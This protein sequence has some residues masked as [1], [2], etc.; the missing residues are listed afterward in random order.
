MTSSD[1]TELVE[2]A[3]SVARKVSLF[4]L[5]RAELMRVR[6][7]EQVENI[8]GQPIW[9]SMA[10][11]LLPSNG[12]RV[13]YVERAETDDQGAVR[14]AAVRNWRQDGRALLVPIRA[15][16]SHPGQDEVGSDKE[17]NML[18]RISVRN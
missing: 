9:L 1:V 7:V 15:N 3:A 14:W 8:S 10:E 12:G 16:S 5:P 6:T 18:L 11:V 2:P 4:M 13:E 17:V